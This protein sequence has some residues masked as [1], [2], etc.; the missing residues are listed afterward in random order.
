VGSVLDGDG[1]G[2]SERKVPVSVSEETLWKARRE[3]ARIWST[4]WL[5]NARVRVGTAFSS[6]PSSRSSSWCTSAVLRGASGEAGS[7]ASGV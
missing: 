1:G 5:V 7:A 2:A 6:C 4:T 3:R